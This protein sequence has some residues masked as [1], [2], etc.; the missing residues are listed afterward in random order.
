MFFE[1]AEEARKFLIALN[2]YAAMRK[3]NVSWREM[4]NAVSDIS[5]VTSIAMGVGFIYVSSC[6]YMTS[7]PPTLTA[8]SPTPI[9]ISLMRYRW[10]IA[11]FRLSV[12]RDAP[13]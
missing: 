11:G 5:S 12:Q 8:L 3:V 10:T 4:L 7:L 9:T 6:L 2:S 1:P 13:E